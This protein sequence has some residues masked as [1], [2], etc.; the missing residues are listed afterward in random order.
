MTTEY[1][2]LPGDIVFVEGEGW[3]VVEEVDLINVVV[4]L[5]WSARSTSKSDKIVHVSPH[6]IST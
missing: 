3:G 4:R 5:A 1:G 6:L 2:F